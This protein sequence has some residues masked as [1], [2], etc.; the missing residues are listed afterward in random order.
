MRNLFIG[1]ICLLVFSGLA[2]AQGKKELIKQCVQQEILD[3]QKRSEK[4]VS[5][6]GD[7]TCPAADVVGFPPK[8]RKHN[9]SGRIVLKAGMGRVFCP[10]TRPTLT[11]VSDNGGYQGN[12]E[13]NEPNSELGLSYGCNGAGVSQGRRWWKG[14]LAA[15]SCA[16]ITQEILLDLTLNCAA[17]LD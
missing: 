12:F 9:R 15:Q 5:A 16:A 10:W 11:D 6:R 4:P 1:I 3:F 13:L 8:T 17:K 2:Q 7:T 14:T